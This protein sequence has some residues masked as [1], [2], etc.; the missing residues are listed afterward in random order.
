MNSLFPK[1]LPLQS[2]KEN[3][4]P[5]LYVCFS[6]DPSTRH[7][8]TKFTKI[9]NMC[10]VKNLLTKRSTR[11]LRDPALSPYPPNIFPFKPESEA[12]I[13]HESLSDFI[14]PQRKP[15]RESEKSSKSKRDSKIVLQPRFVPLP[16]PLPF[17]PIPLIDPS[18]RFSPN[19]TTASLKKSTQP[20]SFS[21]NPRHIGSRRGYGGS[22]SRRGGIS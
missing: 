8:N 17:L 12:E 7:S 20:T 16:Q 15:K 11:N 10:P 2:Y 9:H 13:R 1:D 5:Y 4:L 22:R 18:C 21:V 14:E 3:C 19:P 6:I